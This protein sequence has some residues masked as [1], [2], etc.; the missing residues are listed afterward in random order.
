MD[1]AAMEH[2]RGTTLAEEVAAGRAEVG[3]VDDWIDRWHDDPQE[4]RRV[5]VVMG[6][7]KEAYL[8]WLE[9]TQPLARLLAGDA[10][11]GTA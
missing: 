4:R 11:R 7:S 3:D 5:H 6:I 8:E 9:K 2:Q 1:R 10:G